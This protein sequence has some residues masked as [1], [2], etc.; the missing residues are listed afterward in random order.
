MTSLLQHLSV[1]DEYIIN[2]V[3]DEA[4]VPFRVVIVIV[5]SVVVVIV[6]VTVIIVVVVVIL[7]DTVTG[8]PNI[9]IRAI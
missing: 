9:L 2:A 7:K 5:I 1:C 3:G 6:V 4:I 8:V